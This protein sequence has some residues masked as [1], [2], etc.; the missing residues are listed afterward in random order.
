MPPRGQKKQQELAKRH[1]VTIDGYDLYWQ[2]E[3]Q[4]RYTSQYG[5]E[6]LRIFA[7]LATDSIRRELR[8]E[9][10]IAKEDLA[11]PR[12]GAYMP[13]PIKIVPAVVE[14]GILLAIEAGWNP[15]SRGR[16]FRYQ[17]PDGAL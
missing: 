13:E 4:P 5:H 6:G 10:P 15:T 17:I 7:R 1:A 14:A 9:F 12:G 16:P 8:L 3:S 11:R 2:V